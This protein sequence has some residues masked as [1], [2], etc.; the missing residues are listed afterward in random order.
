[1]N[2]FSPL[3]A[4]SL[5]FP[6]PGFAQSDPA[7]VLVLVNDSVGP[8]NG[9]QG[10]GASVFVG[11]HYAQMRGVPA[12]HVL[13]LNIPVVQ[14]PPL[15]WDS[16][17]IT[18]ST[19][20]STIRQPLLRYLQ[21]HSLTDRIHYIVTTYGIPIRLDNG[22]TNEASLDSF[23]AAINANVQGSQYINPYFNGDPKSAPP[24]FASFQNPLGWKMYLVTR[25]DG[26]T[27]AIAAALVDKAVSAETTMRLSEGTNYF[28][29]RH[30]GSGDPYY[31]A[32]QTFLSA[33]NSSVARGFQSVL[34]DQSVTGSLLKSAPNALFAYGWYTLTAFDGYRFVNGAM[35]C[36]LSSLSAIS[37][38]TDL[39]GS[40]APIWL[41]AGV[42]AL[43]GA[44]TEP[45]LSGF[46][47]GDNLFNHFWS[48]FNFAESAYISSPL[49]N[50]AMVFVGDPLYAPRLFSYGLA[51]QVVTVPAGGGAFSA[52]VAVE[53]DVKWTA[54]S[55]AGWVSVKTAQGNGGGT[56]NF[57]VAGNPTG[58][59]RVATVTV[60][61]QTLQV[62]QHPSAV[63]PVYQDV[64][65]THPYSDFINLLAANGIVTECSSGNYCPDR[66]MTRGEMAAFL[67][68]A[69]LRTDIFPYLAT[70]YFEDVPASHPAFRYVQKMKELGITKGC[71]AT[72]FCPD[73]AVTRGQMAVF[74]VAG[75]GAG[76][77]ALPRIPYFIDVA[78]THPY[79]GSIQ[80][81]R[82][83][84]VTVGCSEIQYCP[85]APATRG[86]MA[87]FLA[88]TFLTGNP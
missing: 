26:P 60:G 88:R 79:Y 80:Q 18:W 65:A 48:G 70:P 38:R 84:G 69:A 19:Y 59:A 25:L 14:T 12:D 3:V 29:Y 6:L 81:I 50:H 52:R 7:S 45:Y 51:P 68:R 77:A 55:E 11:E 30:L 63:A 41:R 67:V 76:S 20:D 17:N 62:V 35:A 43:W 74:L 40:F 22:T 24:R 16:W 23:L 9:T 58:Q 21:N 2:C 36:H 75:K 57:T 8:E 34:N 49:L 53:P 85:D 64:P 5:L 32:D 15:N 83:W 10:K 28:D 44:T 73:D 39:P 82:Q 54:G 13:H 47:L 86:Q 42:T 66:P 56:V 33:Y 37:L 87:V 27:A 78:P 4:L 71:S 1:M 72:R 31:Y 61:T 46:A